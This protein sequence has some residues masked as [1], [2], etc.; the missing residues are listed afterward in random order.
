MKALGTVGKLREQEDSFL[1]LRD[2]VPGKGAY[3]GSMKTAA[4][5]GK[6]P[7]RSLPEA[8]TRTLRHEVGDL[9]QTLYATVAILQKRLPA[10]WDLERRILSDM[11]RRAESCKHML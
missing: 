3:G 9:L 6:T 5:A 8:I 2:S 4:K 11:R 7:P 10:D 1:V